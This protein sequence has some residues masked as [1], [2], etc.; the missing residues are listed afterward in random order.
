M[1]QCCV[2]VLLQGTRNQ[3]VQF[4]N[5]PNQWLQRKC[6][7]YIFNLQVNNSNN[8]FINWVNFNKQCVF[9]KNTQPCPLK[10]TFFS[11]SACSVWKAKYT[12]A[13]CIEIH[14]IESKQCP[15]A[16]DQ[17]HFLNWSTAD[18]RAS[19]KQEVWK[20]WVFVTIVPRRKHI[21]YDI[22]EFIVA[23]Y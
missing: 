11:L 16:A 6:A 9:R 10:M 17:R 1:G 2:G 3:K 13:A 23:G 15:G 8:T 20:N 19:I 4:E 5:S 7:F 18:A 22:R 12:P 21:K 14:I